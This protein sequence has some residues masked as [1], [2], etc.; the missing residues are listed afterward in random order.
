MAIT[1]SNVPVAVPCKTCMSTNQCN[2]QYEVQGKFLYK[3]RDCGDV[4]LLS[5]DQLKEMTRCA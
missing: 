1:K 5:V 2:L 4:R 3:C